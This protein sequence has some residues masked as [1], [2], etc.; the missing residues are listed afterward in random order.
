MGTTCESGDNQL[1]TCH[2]YIHEETLDVYGVVTVIIS[3]SLLLSKTR[4]RFSFM[5]SSMSDDG[6]AAV[7][8]DFEVENY[9]S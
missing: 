6:S 2:D 3:N 8:K 1:L 7:K 9:W 5:L 4:K